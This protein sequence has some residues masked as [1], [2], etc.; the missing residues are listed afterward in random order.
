M[1][2]VLGASSRFF[3]DPI[4]VPHAIASGSAVSPWLFVFFSLEMDSAAAER[5]EFES[6]R[7]VLLTQCLQEVTDTI[8]SGQKVGC[9]STFLRTRLSRQH[10]TIAVAPLAA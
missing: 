4:G 6:E 10:V 3:P 5:M 8:S 7:R 2:W 1:A 9:H